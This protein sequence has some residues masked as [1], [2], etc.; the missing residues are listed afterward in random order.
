MAFREVGVV[1]VREVLRGWLEGVLLRRNASEVE[2]G[3]GWPKAGTSLLPRPT[4][5]HP[6]VH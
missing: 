5:F 3:L 6:V 4:D 1:E 2:H